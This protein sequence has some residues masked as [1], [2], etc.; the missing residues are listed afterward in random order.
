[1][2]TLKRVLFSFAWMLIVSFLISWVPPFFFEIFPPKGVKKVTEIRLKPD[3]TEYKAGRTIREFSALG[4]LTRCYFIVAGPHQDSVHI[5]EGPLA[6][7]DPSG[8]VIK[9]NA[10]PGIYQNL[11]ADLK[12]FPDGSMSYLSGDSSYCAYSPSGQLISI[13][14]FHENAGKSKAVSKAEFMYNKKGF[15]TEEKQLVA[16]RIEAMDNAL[17]GDSL[18]ESYKNTWLYQI[19]KK[20]KLT[21]GYKLRYNNQFSINDTIEKQVINRKGELSEKIAYR[22]QRSRNYNGKDSVCWVYRYEYY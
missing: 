15:I 14:K 6:E 9:Y 7:L 20:K 8:R 2:Y 21:I 16:N 11:S 13:T 22:N 3:G 18:V 4:Q 10:Q 17:P 5:E 19:D 1:M 12:Y